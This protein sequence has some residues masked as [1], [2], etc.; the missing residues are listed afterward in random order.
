MLRPADARRRWLGVLC[1]ALAAGML[2]WG[3]TVLES[4]LKG[5]SFLIYW[6]ICFVFTVG[7]IFIAIFDIRAL[8][9]RTRDEHKD[10]V[11]RTLGALPEDSTDTSDRDPNRS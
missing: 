8:R 2:F 9:Q 3:Q 10:L 4:R 11:E 7:A 1:L 6:L 5:A